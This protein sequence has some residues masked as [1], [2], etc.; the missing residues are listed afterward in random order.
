MLDHAILNDAV[1]PTIKL[2]VMPSFNEDVRSG[3]LTSTQLAEK[4]HVTIKTICNYAYHRQ[5]K[6]PKKVSVNEAFFE[7]QHPDMAYVLGW[8]AAGIRVPAVS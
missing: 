5:I 4:Y 3:S 6:L 1:V 8:L 2:D 7:T